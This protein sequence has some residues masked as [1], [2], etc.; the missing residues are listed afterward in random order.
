MPFTK[1][2]VISVTTSETEKYIDNILIPIARYHDIKTEG[3]NLIE[4][5]RN[6]EAMLII[7]NTIYDK[8]LLQLSFR[9]GDQTFTPE[10][11]NTGHEENYLPKRI[12]RNILFSAKCQCRERAIQFLTTPD[13]NV[14]AM[15]TFSY[16]PI[17]PKEH[18]PNG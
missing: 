9:Y 11:N 7:E 18:S 15:F 12:R 14:S 16:H 2:E 5:R 8:Q 6:C 1:K 4:K 10:D 17:F 3:L 13:C